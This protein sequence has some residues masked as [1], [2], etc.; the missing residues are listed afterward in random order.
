MDFEVHS[1]LGVTGFGTKGDARRR[2]EPFYRSHPGSSTSEEPAFFTVQRR[3][4]LASSRQRTQGPRSSYLGGE[5]FLDLVDGR[6]G[7]FGADLR[8]LGVQA[9]CTNRDLPLRMPVGDGRTDF[10]VE[11]G[12]PVESVRCV[13]GPSP[14]RPSHAVGE[15]SWRL[16][17]HLSHNYL[18]LVDADDGRGATVL[19][20]LLELY[21]D[22]SDPSI[23]RQIGGV[24]SAVGRPAV[25]RL[26]LDGRLNFVRGVEIT[27]ECD[28]TAFEGTSVALLGMVLERFF[29]GYVSINS[30]AETVLRSAQRGEI[31]RWPLRIGRR[32][33]I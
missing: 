22:L 7:P 24:R 28:E 20:E 32:P 26:S 14:P 25:R 19:R 5:V 31:A 27:L 13:A 21:G 29:G 33:T 2:F 6:E 12:A 11:S 8:Q 1:V 15:T 3:P 18:S 16:I 17:S 23:R 4:R 30:F 9:L 10:F